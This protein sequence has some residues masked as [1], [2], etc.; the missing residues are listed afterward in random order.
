MLPIPLNAW[1]LVPGIGT[2]NLSQWPGYA[3]SGGFQVWSITDV[4]PGGGPA[5]HPWR[6]RRCQ[7]PSRR[8]LR[9]AMVSRS[10]E[11]RRTTSRSDVRIPANPRRATG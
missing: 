1:R 8:Y 5:V 3:R 9:A 10:R 6:A 2:R 7:D 4:M 11:R